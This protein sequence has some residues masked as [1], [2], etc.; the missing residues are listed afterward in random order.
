MH[1]QTKEGVDV[2]D[3]WLNSLSDTIAVA[4]I[5]ARIDRLQA[6]NFGDHKPVATS[7]W[8]LRIDHGP[9]YRVYYALAG[10]RVVLLLSGGDKRKQS[11]DI[12]RAIAMWKDYNER[13]T[14]P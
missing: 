7:V 3:S 13:E 12:R 4:R 10:R 2:F 11:A 8:E 9:G 6:G 1:Y 14:K 5:A